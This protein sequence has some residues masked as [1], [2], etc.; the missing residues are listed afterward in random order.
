[1][2]EGKLKGGLIFLT[3]L[4]YVFFLLIIPVIFN[5]QGLFFKAEFFITAV[6]LVISV[7]LIFGL[8]NPWKAMFYF[9]II[10]IVNICGI[11]TRT[12]VLAPLAVPLIL[13]LIGLYASAP[14]S[15]THLTLPTN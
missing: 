7:I 15:Y 6:L 2:S 4:T 13:L 10:C 9:Y 3:I 8:E 1:M 5:F 14:V 12:F 11:Y